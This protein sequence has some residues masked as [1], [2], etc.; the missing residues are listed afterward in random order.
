MGTAIRIGYRQEAYADHE[1]FAIPVTISEGFD[2]EA[3]RKNLWNFGNACRTTNGLAGY[4]SSWTFEL[5]VLPE[6]VFVLADC[7]S[8]IAD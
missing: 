7:R 4:G 6:G 1:D 3:C 8:S 2:I 5:V